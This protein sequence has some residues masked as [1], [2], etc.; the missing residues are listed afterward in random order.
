[1]K[2][3]PGVSTGEYLHLRGQGDAGPQ[4]GP[5][6]DLHVILEVES[7]PGFERHGRDVLTEVRLTPARAALG[8]KVTVAT[9]EGEATLDVPAGVQP[10]TLLRLKGKGLPPL[11][12]GT[13]G[14]QLVRAV[15]EVPER[16]GREEKKLY[17]QLLD[18]EPTQDED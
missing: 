3:P 9:L 8:G 4:G 5:P 14:S 2:I 1:V 16:L 17:K 18:L 7:P 15:L 10:G 6:G 13:R 11:H 12:G